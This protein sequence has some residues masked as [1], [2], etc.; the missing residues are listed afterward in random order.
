MSQTQPPNPPQ[1]PRDEDGHGRA[2]AADV[3]NN[4]Y[5]ARQREQEEADLDASAPELRS[6]ETQRLNRKALLFLAAII[7]V[8][9]LF[10]V[11]VM[12]NLDK[13]EKPAP[14]REES[15]VVPEL[16]GL[17][18]PVDRPPPT[19]P[20]AV[21]P[22]LP[23]MPEPPE[24]TPLPQQLRERAAPRQPSLLERR[25]LA[26]AGGDN[27]SDYGEAGAA[28]ATAPGMVGG[29]PGSSGQQQPGLAGPE[30][31]TSAR[32]IQKPNALLVRGTYIRCV[33]ET[34][35]VSDLAGYTSCIVTEPVYSIN[36][37]NLLLPKGSKILGSYGNGGGGAA[38]LA[39]VAVVWDRITTPTGIDVSMSSPGVDNLGGSGIPGQYNAHWGSRI[40]SALL[41]SLISDGFK[42][43]A[44]ENGPSSYTYG[45]SG[46]IVE[47]P[48]ESAT[49][50][51]MER[52]ANEAL[53]ENMQR[54]PTV[55]VNQGTIINVYVSRDVDFSGV[56]ALY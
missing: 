53:N 40:T 16:R 49:A 12:R 37:Y 51:T 48:Y 44:A 9:V 23:P 38:N 19:E 41:I 52:L 13:D 17:P 46:L 26:S 43:A 7:A 47:Q 34:R 30:K 21:Q 11:L 33:L 4:P 8:L 18:S 3:A 50:R 39:R 27:A 15:V 54:R 5:Y 55:T 14:K 45:G 32:F 42:Y 28:P 22:S 10:A 24:P 6:T 2:D 31:P 35:I 36:G 56:V 29:M 20:I 25:I 1:E